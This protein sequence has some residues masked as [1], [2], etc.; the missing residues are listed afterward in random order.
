[1]ATAHQLKIPM[2]ARTKKP[3]IQW[4]SRAAGLVD[5]PGRRRIVASSR[6]CDEP[7]II[8]IVDRDADRS[9]PSVGGLP[10]GEAERVA[11]ANFIGDPGKNFRHALSGRRRERLAAGCSGKGPQH[12][13]PSVMVV[14]IGEDDSV[15]HRAGARRVV[16]DLGQG[17]RAGVIPPVAHN[18]Q[19]APLVR[20]MLCV[21]ERAI[22][23]IVQSSHSGGWCLGE[24]GPENVDILRRYEG[25]L[26]P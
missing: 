25:L 19:E 8:R 22:E 9:K 24:R 15:N 20:A 14:W 10:R 11:S 4:S 17:V 7:A 2:P 26:K 5:L 1:M 23:R 21:L 3:S 16:H 13:W 18:N 6:A 12:T